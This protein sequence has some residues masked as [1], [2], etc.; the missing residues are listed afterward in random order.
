MGI[1]QRADCRSFANFYLFS[2]QCLLG[3]Q[4]GLKDV[5]FKSKPLHSRLL[6]SVL[7]ILCISRLLVLSKSIL[8]YPVFRSLPDFRV[9]GLMSVV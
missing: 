1:E 8:L 5:Y 6:V 9:S 3:D 7:E 4:G 2:S